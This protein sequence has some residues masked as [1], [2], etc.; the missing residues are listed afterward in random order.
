MSHVDAFL[1]LE[2]IPLD[3]LPGERLLSTHRGYCRRGHSVSTATHPS[4]FHVTGAPS[5]YSGASPRAFASEP[6]P[7]LS[8]MRWT[9]ARLE[10]CR[11]RARSYSVPGRCLSLR[12]GSHCS[13]GDVMGC[14]LEHAISCPAGE[15]EL[16]HISVS[17][18]DQADNLRRLVLPD[19]DSNV[20]SSAYP[21]S[22]LLGGIRRW[23]QRDR[24]SLPLHC[25][26]NQSPRW[27]ACLTRASRGEELHLYDTQVIKD[28][29]DLSPSSLTHGVI[30]RE[31]IAAS[32]C[33]RLSRAPSTMEPPTLIPDL[34]GRL[35]FAFRHEPPTFIK[36][37]SARYCRWRFPLRPIPRFAVSRTSA[38]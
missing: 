36:M 34:R 7:L 20:S 37:D 3:L 15:R 17:V 2:D 27:G 4:T 19:D 11:E 26:E 10:E 24:H 35:S 28:L 1:Q 14:S 6:I 30:S 13:P 18:L 23:V 31:R 21:Y 9:P 32:P 25:I 22:T 12:A 29:F 8:R 33:T 38:R 16:S 5:A